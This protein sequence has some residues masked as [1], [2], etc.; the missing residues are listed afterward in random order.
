MKKILLLV[1]V[2]F[3]LSSVLNAQP[4]RWQQ[5]VK[6]IMNIDMNVQ[7]NRFTGKQKLEYW[8]NSPDTLTK[9]F[10]HLYFNAFQ[11]GSMMDT[12]SRRQ[13]VVNGPGARPDW[14]Q[15]VK[16]RILNLEPDEIGYQKIISLKMNGIRQNFKTLET[17]LEVKLSKPILPRSKVM[18]DMEFE[19]QVPLQIR[20]SGRDNPTTKVRYSMSQ[21]YPKICEYDYE[22]WHP[23]PYVGREF[24]GVWGDF[25]VSISIDKKYILG[26]T[27]YLQNPNEVGYGY[28]NPGAKVTRASGD[29]LT[30]RFIAPNVHDFMWA[31]DPDYI[32][33][34]RKIKDSLTIHVLYKPTNEPAKDWEDLLNMAEK[35]MPFVE[36]TFGS[37]PY[38]QFSF[39]HG[40]D[41]G[42]EYP[43]AT[44]C[45]GPGAGLHEFLHSW[46]YGMLG[47]NESLYP[48]MDEG[49]TQYAE[50]RVSAF[51]KNSTAFA[52]ASAYAGYYSLVKSGK[53]EPLTTHADHY[54]TNAAY[55]SAAYRKGAVFIE[56]L[57]YI[58][59][60]PVRDKILL[61][62]YKQWRFKHPNAADF[63]RVAEKVS[64]MK[65][66]W[67][68]EYW[69]NSTKTIDYS[70]DSLWEEAGKTKVRLSRIGMM[71]MPIDLQITLKDGNKELHYVPM[72]LM[73]GEK[74]VEDPT[75]PRKTYEPWKWTHPT[76]TI[77]TNRKLA[78]FTIVE[79]DASQRMADVERKNNRLEL[80]W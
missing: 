68:K 55:S 61:E 56:Q 5:R 32:H 13:G 64:G 72:N 67:Y 54:N 20:R 47:T 46:Y 62:Y 50:E 18:F 69:I 60:A 9:I 22:G 16:D 34:S 78:D 27:G 33:V 21:W 3:Q 15:R 7:T 28:E 25:D 59:G 38:K 1:V 11:P 63:I 36:K 71:P 8:N 65:L 66:D 49:F 31:A 43:M 37:Y 70:I 6:Y 17:I 57:G 53:E 40:G 76:Y 14:D 41:G 48:W 39:I 79:I 42:M 44:L 77:E 51:L 45:I 35:A 10:Y 52:Q 30:W 2:I 80:K 26:G 24:Y 23:T 75:I 74:P 29:K 12:R 58:V 73:Y 19:A 4:D